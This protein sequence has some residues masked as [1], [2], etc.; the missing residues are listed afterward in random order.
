MLT[1]ATRRDSG[2]YQIRCS[3]NGRAYVG[4]AKCFELR[5]RQHRV[6]L[7]RNK[8]H[9]IHLQRSWN[10]Y[11]PTAF[12]FVIVETIAELERL[13]AR[14][15]YWIDALQ[16]A[17]QKY[18]F[19]RSPTAGSQLGLKFP[20]Q[21]VERKRAQM[22]GK[23]LPPEW[24]GA[25]SSALCGKHRP[26]SVK[27]KLRAFHLGRKATP[28]QRAKMSA[29][30]KARGPISAETRRKMAES[31]RG[32]KQSAEHIAKLIIKRRK[33]TNE[34]ASSAAADFILGESLAQIGMR[35]GFNAQTISNGFKR[36]GF[37]IRPYCEGRIGV[38]RKLCEAA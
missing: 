31:L 33:F 18:G 10:K 9:S 13:V 12:S 20:Q 15:Q 14:E 35:I 37:D 1:D 6:S 30:H 32:Y 36:I 2:I 24:R 25:I 26:Q 28:E 21:A 22:T 23:K 34:M 3:A 17:N 16:S 29:A 5:W 19:N 38:N 11:G 27:D 4:S 8:H 7:E